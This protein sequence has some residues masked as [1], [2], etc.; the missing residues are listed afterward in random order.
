MLKYG[1]QVGCISHSFFPSAS[2]GLEIPT[3]GKYDQFPSLPFLKKS[4]WSYLE[5][6]SCY[7]TTISVTAWWSEYFRCGGAQ[8]KIPP[9]LKIFESIDLRWWAELPAPKLSGYISLALDSENSTIVWDQCWY[10]FWDCLL[11][12]RV[13]VTLRTRCS[14][15][16]APRHFGA[17]P[18][19]QGQG[20]SRTS[21]LQ[22]WGSNTKADTAGSCVTATTTFL[23]LWKERTESWEKCL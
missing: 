22:F 14:V 1:K 3:E 6:G 10:H 20:K 19:P 9:L 2:P 7:P 16:P 18:T 21:H 4:A 15:P 12:H 23:L 11:F 13:P 8:L 17:H 5:H